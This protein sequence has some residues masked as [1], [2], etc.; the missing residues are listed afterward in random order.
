MHRKEEKSVN[1]QR[2]VCAIWNGAI[3]SKQLERSCM[4][5][6]ESTRG[7]S[8]SYMGFTFGSL[9]RAFGALDF[10]ALWGF[11]ITSP[12]AKPYAAEQE[13]S[14]HFLTRKASTMFIR[15]KHHKRGERP[16][17][18]RPMKRQGRSSL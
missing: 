15:K 5:R 9:S 6:E 18:K 11:F 14:P 1:K 4:P 17:G 7:S 12:I 8:L 16:K 2:P 13:H 10:F 3:E